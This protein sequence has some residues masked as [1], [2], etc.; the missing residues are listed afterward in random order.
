[1]TDELELFLDQ[2]SKRLFGKEPKSGRRALNLIKDD[3][4]QAFNPREKVLQALAEIRDEELARN[5]LGSN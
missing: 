4:N 2:Q 1:M 3:F 5:K